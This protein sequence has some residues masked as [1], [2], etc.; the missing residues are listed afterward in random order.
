MKTI[1]KICSN[2]T[3]KPVCKVIKVISPLNSAVYTII[4]N[5]T[6]VLVYLTQV[7]QRCL[8]IGM[9]QGCFL[10]ILHDEFE[11]LFLY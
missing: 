11:T 6:F 1:N 7:N 10:L 8:G 4:H 3:Q 9:L 5:S 2:Q